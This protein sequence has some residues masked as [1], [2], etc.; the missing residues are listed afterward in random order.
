MRR[1]RR[2]SPW[3]AAMWGA[4]IGVL[5]AVGTFNKSNGKVPDAELAGEITGS[6]TFPIILFALVAA[7]RNWAVGVRS[8]F[9][10]TGR[11]S[12]VPDW[13]VIPLGAL[14]GELHRVVVAPLF[15]AATMIATVGRD[16]KAHMTT[17]LA[18]DLLFQWL[19]LAI[20]FLVAMAVSRSRSHRCAHWLAAFSV[21]VGVGLRLA[22][23]QYTSGGYPLWYE[24]A[25]PLGSVFAWTVAIW[26]AGRAA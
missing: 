20:T 7:I 1:R 17:F 19:G 4:G 6:F 18:L 5:A 9:D 10:E 11:R 2:W 24:I 21:L 13:L 3:R 22:T 25:F 12:G 16:L 15:A 23:G 14:V 8:P 26:Y